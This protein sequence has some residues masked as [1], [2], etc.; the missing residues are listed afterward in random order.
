MQLWG[1]DYRAVVHAP[2]ALIVAAEFRPE[3]AILDLC[4][5]RM[6][7]YELARRLRTLP[8]L[9]RVTLVAAGLRGRRVPPPIGPAGFALHLVKP[10]DPQERKTLLAFLDR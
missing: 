4:L 6:D 3:I 9:E 2:T 1:Y 5:P 8:G 10:V 7:G